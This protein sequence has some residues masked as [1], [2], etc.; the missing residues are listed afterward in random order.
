[1]VAATLAAWGLG[2]A[3]A[4][5]EGEA[6]ASEPAAAEAAPAPADDEELFEEIMVWGDLF[7]RWDDTRW[8]VETEIGL[9]YPLMLQREENLEI[10]ATALQIR[11]VIRCNKQDR[12]GRKRYEVDCVLEDV[13]LQAIPFRNDRSKKKLGDGQLV[14]DQLDA[15]LTGAALQLQ[16]SDDGR[17]TNVDLEGI[18]KFNERVSDIHETLRQI[19]SRLVVGF[20]MKLRKG[21]QLNEGKWVEYDSAL[22]TMPTPPS[23]A[24]TQGSSMVVHYLNRYEGHVLVQSI[25]K[26]LIVMPNFANAE[27]V[28]QPMTIMAELIG[29]SIFD[30]REGY[31][32]E[33]VWSLSGKTTASTLFSNNAYTHAGRI[34]MLGSADAPDC[35]PTRLVQ[36]ANEDTHDLPYW[37]SIEQ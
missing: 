36:G 27:G 4:Q 17:V 9:P 37:Q 22:M 7:A 21:N 33:R 16:V 15:K 28:E 31:M 12:L 32:T 35:G 5:S 3:W 19:L 18:P 24:A 29:V 11:G 2:S 34:R 30:A 10:R 6:S 13:A 20:D 14:L 26:S 23:I 8:F 1:M 25:G